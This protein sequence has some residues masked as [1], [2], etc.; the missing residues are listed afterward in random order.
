MP[1]VL[2]YRMSA[3]GLSRTPALE[4]DAVMGGG[5][6]AE[7][8]LTKYPVE[9]GADVS[10]HQ[11]ESPDSH[12]VE[13]VVTDRPTN[14]EPQPGRARAAWLTLKELR[15][16][17]ERLILNQPVIGEQLSMRLVRFSFQFNS[18]TGIEVLRFTASFE[19]VQVAV[20]QRVPAQKRKEAKTKP[21]LELGQQTTG[22]TDAATAEKS[23]TLLKQIKDSRAA[24]DFVKSIFGGG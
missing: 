19:E 21:S 17:K 13:A 24:R 15:R 18:G 2:L 3:D 12:Q 14:G 16:S 7:S 22:A 4:V 5:T 1:H 6:T 8:Q 20:S 9:D 11:V 23:K 10:D